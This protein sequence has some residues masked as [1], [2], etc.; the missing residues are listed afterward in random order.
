MSVYVW[1]FS[2]VVDRSVL[3]NSLFLIL[4]WS[5]FI[6]LG[7]VCL[8]SL[9]YSDCCIFYCTCVWRLPWKLSLLEVYWSLSS[10]APYGTQMLGIAVLTVCLNFLPQLP[11]L[12]LVMWLVSAPQSFGLS[13]SIQFFSFRRNAPFVLK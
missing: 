13:Q 8:F 1:G 12:F 10:A 3:K 9:C 7:H 6:F 11:A 5:I 4:F 2:Y